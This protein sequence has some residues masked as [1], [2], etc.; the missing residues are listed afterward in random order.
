MSLRQT[1]SP[2]ERR[3]AEGLLARGEDAAFDAHELIASLV[4]K[5]GIGPAEARFAAQ[6]P[7]GFL[8]TTVRQ[9]SP[10]RMDVE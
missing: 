9:Q 7:Y 3:T 6:R 1:N 10:Y 2:R 8:G 4:V 5:T